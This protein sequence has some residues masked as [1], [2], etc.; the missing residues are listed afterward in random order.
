MVEQILKKFQSKVG[1]DPC[2][3]CLITLFSHI[4]ISGLPY[5]SIIRIANFAE[6]RSQIDAIPVHRNK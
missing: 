6:S 4:T 3:R 1:F 5:Y 2:H